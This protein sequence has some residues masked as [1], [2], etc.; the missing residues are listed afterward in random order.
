[1]PV[2]NVLTVGETDQFAAHGGV[3]QLILRDKQVRF[4][5][6]VDA[7]SQEGLKISSKLLALARI[8]SGP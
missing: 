5:I 1:M 4:E 6:N 7:A 2:A 3:I 8:V